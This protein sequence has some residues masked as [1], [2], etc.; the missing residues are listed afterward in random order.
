V[1]LRAKEQTEDGSLSSEIN[2]FMLPFPKI[3]NLPFL[4]ERK[5]RISPEQKAHLF[6]EKS[7]FRT[8]NRHY[9]P[10]NRPQSL[11]SHATVAQIGSISTFFLHYI[12]STF[13][14]TRKKN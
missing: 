7:L 3:S 1:R 11:I 2:I 10:E 8:K 6:T 5:S 4:P 9:S 13:I 14:P 12:A